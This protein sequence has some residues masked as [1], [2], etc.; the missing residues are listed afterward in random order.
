[1]SAAAILKGH[2]SI[3]YSPDDEEETGAGYYADLW[4]ADSGPLCRIAE[5]ARR[6]ALKHGGTIEH[7]NGAGVIP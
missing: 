5:E 7:P 6:W 2:F 4:W 3:A 1:M